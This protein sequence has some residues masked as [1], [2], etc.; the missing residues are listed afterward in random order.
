MTDGGETG[1]R[2]GKRSNEMPWFAAE[3]ALIMQAYIL[4]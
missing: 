4:I 2:N 3:Y 1:A